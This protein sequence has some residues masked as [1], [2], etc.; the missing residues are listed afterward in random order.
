MSYFAP[1]LV[2]KPLSWDAVWWGQVWGLTPGWSRPGPVTP[3]LGSWDPP[4]MS[5]THR[6]QGECHHDELRDMQAARDA[7]AGS[8]GYIGCHVT[9]CHAKRDT[10]WVTIVIF[11]LTKHWE[12]PQTPKWLSQRFII[13]SDKEQASD[14][15]HLY[16]RILWIKFHGR[17][18]LPYALYMS[19]ISELAYEKLGVRNLW[20]YCK[21]FFKVKQ[22]I[23]HFITLVQ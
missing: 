20:L 22:Q 9:H 16:K 4:I 1:N 12:A 6:G 10:C 11:K 13:N 8:N 14:R 7:G 23:I 17:Y 21:D 15:E 18:P 3:D 2:I 5:P 19:S